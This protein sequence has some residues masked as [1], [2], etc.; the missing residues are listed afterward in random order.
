MPNSMVYF[1]CFLQL[2]I[3]SYFF[4]SVFQSAQISKSIT[5]VSYLQNSVGFF[6]I[7]CL[8]SQ[9]LKDIMFQN[10]ELLG[11]KN[12][13]DGIEEIKVLLKYC[14]IYGVLDKVMFVSV[15]LYLQFRQTFEA[16][17]KF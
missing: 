3:L 10:E 6:L 17:G 16:F 7:C 2:F 12:F 13:K 15:I 9:K 1:C 4:Y 8:D 14:E 5:L 11:N